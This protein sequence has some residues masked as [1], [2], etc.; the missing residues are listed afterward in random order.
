M[1]V[2]QPDADADPVARQRSQIAERVRGGGVAAYLIAMGQLAQRAGNA[3]LARRASSKGAALTLYVLFSLAPM[4]ILLVALASIFFDADTVRSALLT[5]LGGLIGTQGGDALKAII[6]GAKQNNDSMAASIISGVI[7]LVT[8]TSAFAELKESLD[9]LWGIPAATGSGIL[10]F[11]KERILSVG[12]LLV[13]SLML[14]ISLAINAALAAL[15][16]QWIDPTDPGKLLQYAFAA[17]TM[18]I[19]TVIFAFI[20]KYLP[21]TRIAWRDVVLGSI[22]TAVLFMIGKF[23][24]GLYLGHGN[25]S[26]SYGAAGSIVALITW[27]YYSAQIFFFGAL[28]THEYAMTL[29]SRKGHASARR[30]AA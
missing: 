23:A 28:F 18:V 16:G 30:P 3:W 25:F 17:L 10:I 27:I 26:D 19:V 12:L 5:Q 22:L 11:M 9:E 14:M 29:G 13:L 6:A 2:V 24:I 8:A 1:Q 15:Q 20:Y 4:L 21:G 7:V